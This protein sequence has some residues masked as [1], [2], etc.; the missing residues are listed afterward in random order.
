M[1]LI[2]FRGFWEINRQKINTIVKIMVY[3]TEI[4]YFVFETCE[5]TPIL[6]DIKRIDIMFYTL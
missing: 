1:S 6:S 5:K 4:Y 3:Y 2:V